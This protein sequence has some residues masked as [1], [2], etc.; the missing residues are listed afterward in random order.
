M[1]YTGKVK[2]IKDKQIRIVNIEPMLPNYSRQIQIS[3]D[4]VS[5]K[6]DEG[7]EVQF[8]YNDKNKV[9]N[10]KI[11]SKKVEVSDTVEKG[12]TGLK[13][14]RTISEMSG[15]LEYYA[16]ISKL[17]ENNGINDLFIDGRSRPRKLLPILQKKYYEYNKHDWSHLNAI[18]AIHHSC[19]SGEEN[20]F[21]HSSDSIKRIWQEWLLSGSATEGI[22]ER[23]RRFGGDSSEAYTSLYRT[24]TRPDFH[25]DLLPKPSFAISF[26]FT[27]AKPYISRDEDSIYVIDNPV[28]KDQVFGLPMIRET[29]WKGHLRQSMRE[30]FIEFPDPSDENKELEDGKVI[31]RLFGSRD[32][33]SGDAKQG[34]LHFYPTF[35]DSISLE[36]INPHSRERRAGTQ[37]VPF[38]SVPAGT[39]GDFIILYTPIVGIAPIVDNLSEEEKRKLLEYN[40]KIIEEVR[41]DLKKLIEGIKAM[42]LIYGFSAKATDSYGL[43]KSNIRPIDEYFPML[44]TNCKEI[45]PDLVWEDS[46]GVFF[47]K[48]FATFNEFCDSL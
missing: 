41:D 20:K 48:S 24:L 36:I 4:S 17:I 11:L 45:A 44:Q 37:P 3:A 25:L 43:A 31:D 40:E 34:Y 10:L 6:L 29:S 32:I 2:S 5:F 19:I 28:V 16:Y 23:R 14:C 30:K 8:E 35:F 38:E 26:R 42:F 1:S 27:L 33:E 47:V 7:D 18:F 13:F 21:K 39:E 9:T 46:N 22:K 12:Y 15:P